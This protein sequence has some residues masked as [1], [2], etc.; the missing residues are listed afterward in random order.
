MVTQQYCEQIQCGC[1]SQEDAG[2]ENLYDCTVQYGSGVYLPTDPRCIAAC[3]P[4]PLP[5][6]IQIPPSASNPGPPVVSD[7]PRLPVL[8]ASNIV[9]PLPDI[10]KV[11]VNPPP[12]PSLWCELNQMIA[13]HPFIA[14]GTLVA[15]FFMLRKN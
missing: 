3:P 1:L 5:P 2:P 11:I 6:A 14:V 9:Q 7:V 15:G 8:T 12:A 13:D 10:T 4:Q